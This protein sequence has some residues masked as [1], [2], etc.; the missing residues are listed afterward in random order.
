MFASLQFQAQI[1]G[2]RA[3]SGRAQGLAHV[4]SVGLGCLLAATLTGCGQKGP[5]FLPGPPPP[6]QP[7]AATSQ[8]L[9]PGVIV[10]AQALANAPN[11]PAA[12]SP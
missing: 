8:P 9:A 5:L 12:T 11:R 2:R 1:L 10:P 4:A 3:L 6:L 7:T